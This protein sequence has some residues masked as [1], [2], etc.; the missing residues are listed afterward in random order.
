M[1]RTRTYSFYK[2]GEV[3]L[4]STWSR[5]GYSKYGLRW[6]MKSQGKLAEGEDVYGLEQAIEHLNEIREFVYEG[7]K[8]NAGK[9]LLVM[10]ETVKIEC[11]IE[12]K[13]N[14]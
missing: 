13:P 9:H 11:I 3:G 1:N 7:K 10:K 14:T 6:K 8:H 4:T 12:S 2:V 5:Q